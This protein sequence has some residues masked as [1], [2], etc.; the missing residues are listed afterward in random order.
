MLLSCGKFHSTRKD[1]RIK[2]FQWN[3][4]PLPQIPFFDA[5]RLD[6]FLSRSESPNE[7]YHHRQELQRVCPPEDLHIPCSLDQSYYLS[8]A[9]TTERDKTQVVVKHIKQTQ[10]AKGN[11]PSAIRPKLLMVNQLWLWGVDSDTIL[12]AFPDRCCKTG[13]PN[14]LESISRSFTQR[15]PPTMQA[16]LIQILR[17]ALDFIDA[18]TNAGLDENVF[19]IFEQSI[20]YRVGTLRY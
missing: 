18:P 6:E 14:L 11:S 16:M 7:G 8:L 1:S 19:D 5:E 4:P 13:K 20:A 2:A 9:D 10:G 3:S 15:P 17:H 12:T